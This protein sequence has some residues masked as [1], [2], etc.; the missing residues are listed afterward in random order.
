MFCRCHPELIQGLNQETP[1][2]VRG[3]SIVEDPL[4]LH[5]LLQLDTDLPLEAVEADPLL[6]PATDLTHGRDHLVTPGASPDLPDTTEQTR[7][8]TTTNGQ[9]VL[10]V[11]LVTSAISVLYLSKTTILIYLE[12]LMLKN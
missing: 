1:C 2:S 4:S 10:I 8:L 6:F 5:D 11:I 9:P 12:N 7:H 3:I